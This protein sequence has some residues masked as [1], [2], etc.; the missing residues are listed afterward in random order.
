MNTA[1]LTTLGLL[2]FLNA[3]AQYPAP[4]TVPLD[5][6]GRN[7]L[8]LKASPLALLDPDGTYE[9]AV[10]W[11]P[12]PR[13]GYQLGVG[14]GNSTIL[15]VYGG[16]GSSWQE[17]LRLRGEIRWYRRGG[18]SPRRSS[19]PYWALEG[20]FKR[21]QVAQRRSVGRECADGTCAYFQN[22]TYRDAK[23]VYALHGKMGWQLTSGRANFDLYFGAGFRQI[24]VSARGLPADAEPPLSRGF[25]LGTWRTDTNLVIPSFTLGWKVGVLLGS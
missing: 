17:V 16:Y 9:G 23:D 14:Y 7:W 8:I 3:S 6:F 18:Y 11:L 5:S 12:T 25:R 10:E 15:P 1:C 4:R 13:R 20:L 24:A 2:F 22:L 21:V 19:N